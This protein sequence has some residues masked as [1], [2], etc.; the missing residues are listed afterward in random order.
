VGDVTLGTEHGA[1]HQPHLLRKAAATTVI[2]AIIF[3]GVYL[4]FGV[5]EM[6]LED[7]LP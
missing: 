4:F 1:P 5:Y 7:L 6:T 3:G 2:A